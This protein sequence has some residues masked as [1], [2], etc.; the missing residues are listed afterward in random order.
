MILK[1]EQLKEDAL[2]M[3]VEETICYYKSIE[4]YIDKGLP[5]YKYI[6]SSVW[7]VSVEVIA[8]RSQKMQC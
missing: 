2:C 8:W 5:K 1:P 7:K 3:L 4:C 6:S